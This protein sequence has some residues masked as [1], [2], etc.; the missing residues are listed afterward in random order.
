MKEYVAKKVDSGMKID[1]LR[2]EKVPFANLE[3]VWEDHNPSPYITRAQMVHSD[4]GI[5]VK[6]STNEWPIRVTAMEHNSTICNDSCMEFFFIPNM[7][8]AEYI[9]IEM[10]PAAIALTAKGPGRGNRP[11]LDIHGE[12]VKIESRVVGECGWSVMA[13]VSYE[14]LLKHYPYCD[15]KTM[16][17]NFYKCG[18]LTVTPHYSTW[19][20]VPTEAPDYHRPEFFG[21]IVLSDEEI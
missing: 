14:F 19:N 10:N 16:R 8:D 9:N 6:L 13:F 20:P 11:R 15:K 5:T 17:A 12:N 21:K 18:N 4:E 2:W 3:H 7:E 1:D